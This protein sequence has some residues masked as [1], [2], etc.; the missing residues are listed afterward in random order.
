MAKAL[1]PLTDQEG[2]VRELTDADFA[3]ALR[4][5]QLSPDHQTMLRKVRG[6]QV[7]PTKVQISLRVS[8]DVLEKFRATGAG[9]QSRMDQA[10]REWVERAA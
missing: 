5:G 2:E 4:F 1:Q 3:R 9:W 10:L 8:Q 6:A 7:A